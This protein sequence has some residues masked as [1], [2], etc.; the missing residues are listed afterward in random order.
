VTDILELAGVLRYQMHLY[1]LPMVR[2]P[3]F[4]VGMM[5]TGKHIAGVT[6]G[7]MAFVTLF[8]SYERA[9]STE[10]FANG[11]EATFF[12]LIWPFYWARHFFF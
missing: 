8:H 7:V 6:Y 11:V 4:R 10:T 2:R 9:N 5:V 3:R 1:R 12:A